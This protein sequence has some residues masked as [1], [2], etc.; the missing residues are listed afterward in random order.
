[1]LSVVTLPL[2]TAIDGPE[3]TDFDFLRQVPLFGSLSDEELT[4][5]SALLAT[6][7]FA[8]GAL[9]FKAGDPGDQLYIIRHGL[10]RIFTSHDNQEI[11][12]TRL[13]AGEFFGDLALLDGSPRMASASAKVATEALILG[14]A[15]LVNLLSHRPQAAVGMMG[16]LARRIREVDRKLSSLASKNV[17]EIDKDARTMGERAADLAA[18]FGG[19]WSFILAFAG[20]NLL[21]ILVNVVLRRP[22]DGYPFVFLNLLLTLIM[23][24]QAPF[25]MMSQNRR[26]QKDRLRADLDYQV[27]LKNETSAG[28]IKD[29]IEE[30]RKIDFPRLLD[31]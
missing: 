31:S 23:T 27:N 25:I 14:R 5:V 1:M 11:E 10:V 20:V 26:S 28:D 21:W 12:L 22:L 7:R 4:E 2:P 17:N 29:S 30:L 16:V 24:L 18:R 3:A 6:Q 15:Q 9:I 13:C 8:A 19:S